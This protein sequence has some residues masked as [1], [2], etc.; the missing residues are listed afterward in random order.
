MERH[1]QTVLLSIITA[2][3]IFGCNQIFGLSV[4]MAEVKITLQ[5]MQENSKQYVTMEYIQSRIK[6]RD[7]QMDA[8]DKRLTKLENKFEKLEP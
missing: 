3:I 6:L 2:G 1:I 4:G 5:Q 7:Q 8:Q